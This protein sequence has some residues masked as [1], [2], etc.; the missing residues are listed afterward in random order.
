ML[1]VMR[2]R[3]GKGGDWGSHEVRLDIHWPLTA[4]VTRT[5]EQHANAQ[6]MAPRQTTPRHIGPLAALPASVNTNL[7]S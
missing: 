5:A 6:E 3:K 4:I 1:T 7:E 2:V